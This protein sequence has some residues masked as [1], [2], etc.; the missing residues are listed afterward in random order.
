MSKVDWVSFL[1][2]ID[3]DKVLF[4]ELYR[5]FHQDWP[6]LLTELKKSIEGGHSKQ[7]EMISHRLK[8][9]TRNFFDLDLAK[10]CGDIEDMAIDGRLIDVTPLYLRLQAE[11]E[12]LDQELLDKLESLNREQ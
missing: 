8:G 12:R 2:L 7:I 9:M 1:N 3:N 6:Q 4:G 11:F 5:L 10:M